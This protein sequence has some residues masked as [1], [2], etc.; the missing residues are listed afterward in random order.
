VSQKKILVRLPLVATRKTGLDWT[1]VA[2]SEL[3][4]KTRYTNQDAMGLILTTLEAC[5][6]GHVK[7]LIWTTVVF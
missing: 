2:S 4:L 1:A 7:Y 5:R 6:A 3:D